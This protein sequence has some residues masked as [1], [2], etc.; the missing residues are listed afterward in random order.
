[1]YAALEA[2]D[3]P[4]SF[5]Q[6]LDQWRARNIRRFGEPKTSGDDCL[7]T[8]AMQWDYLCKTGFTHVRTAWREQLWAVLAARKLTY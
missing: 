2:G 4:E 5:R 8:I 7:E 1:M 3:I 6:A